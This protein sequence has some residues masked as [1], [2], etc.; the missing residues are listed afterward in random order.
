M[1]TGNPILEKKKRVTL[2]RQGQETASYHHKNQSSASDSQLEINIIMEYHKIRFDDV[3]HFLTAEVQGTWQ[4]RPYACHHPDP[5]ISQSHWNSSTTRSGEGAQW[6]KDDFQLSLCGV[7]DIW[8]YPHQTTPKNSSLL[9]T[10][11]WVRFVD[12]GS[13]ITS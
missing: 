5:H 11:V 3:D 6:D 12:F 10:F 4:K 1:H 13:W 2:H 8:G 7:T 9:I